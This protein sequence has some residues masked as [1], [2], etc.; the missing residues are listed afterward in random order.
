MEVMST[1]LCQL[2]GTKCRVQGEFILVRNED[3]FSVE[4]KVSQSELNE[5]K[6]CTLIISLLFD[7]KRVLLYSQI[8]FKLFLLY[9]NGHLL[10]GV[11]H[12]YINEYNAQKS[13]YVRTRKIFKC[14]QI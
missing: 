9:T 1:S 2:P 10:T 14:M 7:E 6:P 8:R 3:L 5:I 11:L 13:I 4:P 12:I